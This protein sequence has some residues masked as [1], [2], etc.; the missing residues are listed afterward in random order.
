MRRLLFLLLAVALAIA[1][2]SASAATGDLTFSSC[3]A[4][5][6]IAGQACTVSAGVL[7][8][9]VGLQVSPDGRS[10]YAIAQASNTLV[11]FDRNA[12]TGALTMQSG[13]NGC[14]ANAATGSCTVLAGELMHPEALAIS[15]DGASVYVVSSGTGGSSNGVVVG[16]S[17]NTATGALTPLPGASGCVADS[18]VGACTVLAGQLFRAGAVSISPDGRSVYAVSTVSLGDVSGIVNVFARDTTTGALTYGS[19]VASAALGSCTVASGVFSLL[20]ASSSKLAMSPDGR[21]AYLNARFSNSLAVFDRDT[22]TGA[23]TLKSGAA[24]CF[25]NAALG[26]C[27]VLGG[28]LPSPLSTTISPDGKNVYVNAGT[29][30]DA[31]NTVV[32]F[33]RDTTTGA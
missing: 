16:F 28:Y 9:V 25:A 18:A 8:T 19:C 7:D 21:N 1:V 33:S 10:A 31:I 15:A 22:T 32:V 23:L 24:G 13:A 30:L 27:T 5:A 26:T 17:R 29:T 6:A 2:P 20:T 11:A 14:F 4:N 12:T 3:Q